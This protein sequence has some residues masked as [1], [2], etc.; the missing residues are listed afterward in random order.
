MPPAGPHWRWR[1]GVARRA[2]VLV[3]VGAE[4]PMDAVDRRPRALDRQQPQR[5]VAP[6]HLPH[7][8]HEAHVVPPLAGRQ[9][10]AV[11]QHEPRVPAAEEAEQHRGDQVY[12]A[13]EHDSDAVAHAR[14]RGAAEAARH[15]LEQQQ[16]RAVAH[17]QRH[18]HARARA[19]PPEH[20]LPEHVPL[21]AD[22]GGGQPRG[23]ADEELV[24]GVTSGEEGEGARVEEEEQEVLAVT[25][26]DGG[27]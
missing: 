17:V 6:H 15:Q 13:H 1:C 23:Q 8:G 9:G 16:R 18:G 22:D 27:P 10:G 2:C 12:R 3:C 11:A 21:H 19:L 5:G 7:V 24:Q 26:A 4:R 25:Q 14:A 20:A